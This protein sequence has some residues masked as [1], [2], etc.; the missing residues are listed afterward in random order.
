MSD[1]LRKWEPT[2]LLDELPEHRKEEL[3]QI[4]ENAANYQIDLYKDWTVG[5]RAGQWF[6]WIVCKL[7][8]T[9]VLNSFDFN[10]IYNKLSNAYKT[11]YDYE[12]SEFYMSYNEKE[13]NS[14]FLAKFISDYVK[15]YRKPRLSNEELTKKIVEKFAF[16]DRT[17]KKNLDDY[18]QLCYITNKTNAQDGQKLIFYVDE[19]GELFAREADEFNYKFE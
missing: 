6:L 13:Y 19:S 3:A 9:K 2:G 17:N 1:L 18:V 10:D 16:I 5:D 11:E 8:N 12:H 14:Q 7:Y 15:P 4:M